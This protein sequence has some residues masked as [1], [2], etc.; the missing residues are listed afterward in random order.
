MIF[1]ME[2]YNGYTAGDAAMLEGE[3]NTTYKEE[4]MC[5]TICTI[6][7]KPRNLTTYVLQSHLY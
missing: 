1:I 4:E 3:I 2:G 5:F 6:N 7:G